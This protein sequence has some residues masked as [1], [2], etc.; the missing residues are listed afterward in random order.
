MQKKTVKGFVLGFATAVVLGGA[1]LTVGAASGAF[2][3]VKA[4]AWYEDAVLWAKDKGI[5]GGYPDGTFKP[6]NNVTRAELTGVLQNM[7]KEGYIDVD[8]LAGLEKFEAIQVGKTTAKDLREMFGEYSPGSNFGEFYV[9][10]G[11]VA[12]TVTFSNDDI[13]NSKWY[14]VEVED[15]AKKKYPQMT[16][17][18]LKK[19]EN[20]MSYEQVCFILGGKGSFDGETENRKSYKWYGTDGS[21][22][23]LT[24]NKLGDGLALNLVE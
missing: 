15:S 12:I 4:G 6:N 9:F 5:V 22:K 1:T 21:S 17:E 14:N 11:D 10:A 23:Q 7:A 16:V 18:N 13:V 19:L 2:T 3:D 8:V 20:G 24:F